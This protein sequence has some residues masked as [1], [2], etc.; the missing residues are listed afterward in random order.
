M[1]DDLSAKLVV[2]LIFAFLVGGALFAVHL[3]I[4][5]AKFALFL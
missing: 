2:G 5:M 3:L 1:S 4:L